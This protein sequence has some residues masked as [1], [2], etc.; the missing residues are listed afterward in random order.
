SE[1]HS[2]VAL[3][4]HPNVQDVE[5][6]THSSGHSSPDPRYRN[7]NAKIDK[8]ILP[9]LCCLYFMAYL[10]RLNIGSA[11]IFYLPQDLHLQSDQLNIALAVF[12]PV[13]IVF[14]APANVLLKKVKPHVFSMP[15]PYLWR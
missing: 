3:D 10:D 15:A 12:F 9:A 5:S 2:A 11:L 13:Y 14:N 7:I 4:L 8:H 6:I 1:K